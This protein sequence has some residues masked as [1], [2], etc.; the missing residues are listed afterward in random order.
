M[1]KRCQCPKRAFFIST[2][3]EACQF[4]EDIMGV[5]A[6][7][8]PFSFLRIYSP[9]DWGTCNACQC[10]KRAFFISTDGVDIF[11]NVLF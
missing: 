3:E 5:N 8:G 2:K 10:P 6:L 7:N 4:L 1:E 11:F 9:S